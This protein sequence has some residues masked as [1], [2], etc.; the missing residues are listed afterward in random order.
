MKKALS[1]AGSDSGGGAGIQADLKTFA[2]FMVY[3]TTAITSV[4]AQNTVGV[5]GVYDLPPDF[6]A[7]QIDAVMKDIGADA[8]KTGMLSSVEIVEA[9]SSKLKEYNV[10][11][12]VVDPVM[13]AKS[14]DV[15]LKEDAIATIKEKLF[16][17]A[18]V[19]TPNLDEA[20]V[21]T[22]IKEIKDEEGMKEAAKILKEMGPKYVL[23]KGGH[24]TDDAVDLLYDGNKFYRYPAKRIAT[25]NTHGT[26]CTYSAAIA[27]CL[28]LGNDVPAAV[29][30]SKKFITTAIR[31]GLEIGKGH[32]PTHHFAELY[33][34]A[35]TE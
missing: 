29:E 8:V 35:E 6:V 11:N 15:L 9:V 14:G 21:L 34:V 26:G 27:A 18:A 17:L 13:V 20:M 10:Q 2:A 7:L 23:V 30:K 4:T 32:G 33:G 5:E 19:I 28:A 31:Y 16:P 22:G 3:G 24:L 12:L 25:R 1:I